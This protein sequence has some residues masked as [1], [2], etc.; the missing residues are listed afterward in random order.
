MTHRDDFAQ[1]N[2]L[3]LHYVDWGTAGRPPLLLL[4]GLAVH[5]RSWD[6]QAERLSAGFHVVAMDQR[7]HGDS[8]RPPP[9]DYATAHYVA[10]MVGIEDALGWRKMSV[11]GQSM[12]GHNG[13]LFAMDHPDRV[14][15]L[16]ISDV[17]PVFRYDLLGPTRHATELPVYARL[18][19]LIEEYRRRAPNTDDATH[20]RRAEHATR[21]LPD[22]RLTLKYD[23]NAPRNWDAVDLWPRLRE[24]RCPTLVLRGEISPVL[25]QED[26]ERMAATIPDC[27]LVVIPGAGHSVASDNPDFF[28]DTVSR[29]LR[30]P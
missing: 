22:G 8:D 18:E 7:G 16:V 21:A 5:A 23:V 3:R 12:G 11:I 1:V 26:A 19:D 9:R 24:I 13:M 29:F 14:E 2:G 20:R 27:R 15:R 28:F 6:H 4:H 10:D 30:Q 17:E 25:R